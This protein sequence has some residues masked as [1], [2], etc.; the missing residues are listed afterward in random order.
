MPVKTSRLADLYWPLPCWQR[1]NGWNLLLVSER[2]LWITTLRHIRRSHLFEPGLRS[3]C[4]NELAPASELSVFVSMA[5]ASAPDLCFFI[6]WFRL[7]FRSCVFYDMAPAS[8]PELCFFITWLWLR[9]RSCVFLWHSSG[10]DSGAVCFYD[11]APAS[12]P[13]LCV[14]MTWLRLRFRSCVFLWHGS[15]F[16]SG[17][18]CFYDMA[19]ASI[20]ELCFF[21]TW[22]RLCFV[23]TL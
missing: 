10:F 22:L 1:W 21:I 14:F 12:I 23:N 19:P 2:R 11:M 3:S 7:R 8:I 20:P 6:T 15:G 18:V 9:F 5:P 17:V 4:K 13:E 16:D